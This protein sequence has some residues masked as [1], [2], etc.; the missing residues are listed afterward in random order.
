MKKMIFMALVAM[1]RWN[2]LSAQQTDLQQVPDTAAQRV[3]S[4]ITA[5]TI[6][7]ITPISPLQL[8]TVKE[9]K[10]KSF[11]CSAAGIIVPAA[12][13]GYG[14]VALHS[15]TLKDLNHSTKTEIQEHNPNFSTGVDNFMQYSPAVAVYVLNAAGV[16]GWHNLRD[17]T[18]ILGL[19]AIINA[20]TVGFVKRQTGE[21]RPDG[22]NNLSFPS[23]HTANAFA[24]AEFL[25]QEYKDVSPWIGI[26]GYA[27]ATATGAMR[28]YNNR[29]WLSDVV[30]GAGFGILSTK[31][32]YWIY[33]VIQRKLF[34]E[35]KNVVM[36]PYYNAQWKT[37][38]VSLSL[39]S[40]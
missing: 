3:K 27:V 8:S 12:M 25:R 1:V 19:A 14:F 34:P 6:P 38:G 17:R 16:K 18:I 40:F 33:P 5:D 9:N 36:L 28:M 11:V 13:I 7:E 15:N 30:A 31:A 32:A 21:M 24:S 26:A 2:S 37:A 39:T 35:H 4:L 29:H 22:S 10:N 23:G 20:S